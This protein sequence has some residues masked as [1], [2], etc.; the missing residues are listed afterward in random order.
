MKTYTLAAMLLVATAVCVAAAQQTIRRTDSVRQ[1]VEK[2]NDNFDETFSGVYPVR[3]PY[4]GA[5]NSVD[6][7][8]YGITSA[9][10]NADVVRVYSELNMM[11]NRII[12]AAAYEF[13]DGNYITSTGW[14][15]APTTS[16]AGRSISISAGSAAAYPAGTTAGSLVLASGVSGQG[17]RKDVE[18]VGGLCVPRIVGSAAENMR[19][20]AA[21]RGPGVDGRSIVLAVGKNAGG[22]GVDGVVLVDGTMDMQNG[23]ITNTR[24]I[25]ASNATALVLTGGSVRVA[26]PM[27]VARDVDFAGNSATN[28]HRVGVA[29]STEAEASVG[30]A[31]PGVVEVV[32]DLFVDGNGAEF[33]LTD[34][35]DGSRALYLGWGLYMLSN[36]GAD[37]H[38]GGN[39]VVEAQ[40]V[41]LVDAG[42]IASMPGGGVRIS[43]QN[44]NTVLLAGVDNAADTTYTYV[45]AEGIYRQSV[46]ELRP[47]TIQGHEVWQAW[48]EDMEWLDG[49][50]CYVDDFPAGPWRDNTTL[51]GVSGSGR[52][53]GVDLDVGG[54]CVSTPTLQAGM[55]AVTGTAGTVSI[56]TSVLSSDG[57][58]GFVQ[59]VGGTAELLAARGWV[60]QQIYDSLAPSA[61]YYLWG[62][63][64]NYVIGTVTSKL[65]TSVS[66]AGRAAWTTT[67]AD[68]VNDQ[69][70][71][72]LT[73]PTN[74]SCRWIMDGVAKVT[75]VADSDDT[76]GTVQAS[77]RI[78][79][80]LTSFTENYAEYTSAQTTLSAT[81]GYVEGAISIPDVIELRDA[82]G[83]NVRYV[84]IVLKAVSGWAGNKTVHSYSENGYLA[85]V[86]LPV[87][88]SY[89]VNS[90]DFSAHTGFVGAVLARGVY[91]E[92]PF[93]E[94]DG[95]FVL[96]AYDYA[97]QSVL[98]MGDSAAGSIANFAVADDVLWHKTITEHTNWARVMTFPWGDQYNSG[99]VWNGGLDGDGI[100]SS[101][102]M[103]TVATVVAS[104]VVLTNGT[105]V[106]ASGDDAVSVYARQTNIMT[107]AGVGVLYNGTYTYV[108]GDEV[109][110]RLDS[111]VEIRRTTV[112]TSEVWQLW[113]SA[114]GY[115]GYCYL[116][117]F[118]YGPWRDPDNIQ[119]PA[120]S[121][122][123]GGT[124]LEVTPTAVDVA[125]DDTIVTHVATSGVDV[126]N[127]GAD[128]IIIA[129]TGLYARGTA[130]WFE[131]LTLSAFE[132]VDPAGPGGVARVLVTSFLYGAEFSPHD[133]GNGVLQL[134]HQY[135]AQSAVYPHIHTASTNTM[136][137]TTNTWFL[138]MTSGRIGVQF[139]NHYSATITVT[140]QPGVWH[141]M[142]QF[143]SWTTN[144][145]ESTIIGVVVSNMGPDTAILVDTDIHIEGEKL[146]EAALPADTP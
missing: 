20:E 82:D 102:G 138:G 62:S 1:M 112:T 123:W 81:P 100:S 49:P 146:G 136:H 31:T 111:A 143:P 51:E 130:T 107:V 105:T 48:E 104:G 84:V 50:V 32:G 129:P 28:V 58:G 15:L 12:N 60:Q 7:G 14:E 2:L 75:L 101:T 35:G 52:W 94:A 57:A 88:S 122:A 134:K 106:F 145:A 9:Y 116:Y 118:P 45:P 37:I 124:E 79:T 25:A 108:S 64:T 117:E 144:M 142:P 22:G 6:L 54:D 127:G 109:Y 24:I 8:D 3:V 125:V 92:D 5:T 53:G 91:G 132:F 59:G 34:R 18:I 70:L 19:V 126:S 41:E 74:E 85:R 27:S 77:L 56:G 133:W 96:R 128:G 71:G 21:S 89:Y 140:N 26:A 120:G 17:Q 78:Y 39:A 80:N 110:R 55:L 139:T 141:R 44:T 63:T 97:R 66:P 135:R 83:N 95:A 67:V 30:F 98:S 90:R 13:T 103:L 76:D 46:Y 115:A 99:P 137:A 23:M 68:V 131:D 114:F 86:E 16:G 73:V 61:Y 10:M 33:N 119:P 69:I 87:S 93:E 4:L 29:V 38:L 11:S 43:E 36:A 65:A 40:D 113:T 72:V 121:G 47:Q 42:R